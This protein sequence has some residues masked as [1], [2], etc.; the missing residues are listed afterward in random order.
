V[1]LPSELSSAV[2]A[3]LGRVP[4]LCGS[5]GADVVLPSI[6]WAVDIL[7]DGTNSRNAQCNA[8]SIGLGFE[9]DEVS[10]PSGVMQDPVTES[11]RCE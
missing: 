11:V 3:Y 2:R 6:F 4:N 1:L 7:A 10:E 9:A 5:I 8:I